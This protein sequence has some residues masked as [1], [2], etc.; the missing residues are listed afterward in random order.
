MLL[1]MYENSWIRI[2]IIIIL[3]HFKNL[4]ATFS[5]R[6]KVNKAYN[7]NMIITSLKQLADQNFFSSL[8]LVELPIYLEKIISR[9][10]ICTLSYTTPA[11]NGELDTL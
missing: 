2:I 7:N 10:F 6:F 5:S 8:Q 4:I 3:V 1:C 11:K 9:L